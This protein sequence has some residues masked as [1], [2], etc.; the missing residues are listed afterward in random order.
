MAERVA[1]AAEA[2]LADP[3]DVGVYGRLVAA[4]TEWRAAGRAPAAHPGPASPVGPVSTV[5]PSAP[6]PAPDP[7]L[8]PDEA[9]GE[10]QAASPDRQPQRLDG[11]LGSVAAELRARGIATV[12][13]DD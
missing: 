13:T 8:D 10:Q 12:P 5:G 11:I 7:D 4:V 2:W 9:T 1:A 3:R 6:A